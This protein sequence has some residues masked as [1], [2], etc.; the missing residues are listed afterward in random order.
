MIS[1]IRRTYAELA[2]LRRL[3]IPGRGRPGVTEQRNAIAIL[4]KGKQT[5][6]KSN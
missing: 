4:A 2:A 3:I 5:L 6:A 1:T